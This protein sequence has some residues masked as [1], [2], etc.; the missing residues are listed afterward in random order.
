ME[1]GGGEELSQERT[2]GKGFE[3]LPLLLKSGTLASGAMDG[4]L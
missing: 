1:E 2:S 3:L 4:W